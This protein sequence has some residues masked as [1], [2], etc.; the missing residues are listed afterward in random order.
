MR[1]NVADV[2]RFMTVSKLYGFV[3]VWWTYETSLMCIDCSATFKTR[4]TPEELAEFPP[5]DIARNFCLRVG[6]VDK[7][8]VVFGWLFFYIG[9]ISL[10]MFIAA[11]FKLQPAARG[12]RR[13]ALI[14]IVVSGI[15][16]ALFFAAIIFG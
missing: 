10:G 8:L 7:F 13:A 1:T 15:F 6:F 5:E 14:G 4:R 12:W 2:F 11:Y 3:P 16:T 9:F